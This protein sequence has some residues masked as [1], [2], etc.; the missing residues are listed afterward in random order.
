M[1][2]EKSP[3]PLMGTVKYEEGFDFRKI[4]NVNDLVYLYGY[5]LIYN[6]STMFGMSAGAYAG[7][8]K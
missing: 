1:T 7:W 5:A 3:Q 2:Y 4:L 8:D 6:V